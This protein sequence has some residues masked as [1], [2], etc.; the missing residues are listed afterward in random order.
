MKKV[1]MFLSAGLIGFGVSHA[2]VNAF[3]EGVSSPAVM[4]TS[5]D[6]SGI[7]PNSGMD[8]NAMIDPSSPVDEMPDSDDPTDS[9]ERMPQV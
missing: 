9:T 3:E 6:D 5:S 2:V 4:L 8:P 7:D 1:A